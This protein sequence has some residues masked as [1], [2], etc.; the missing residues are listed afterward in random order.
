MKGQSW[1]MDLVIAVVI[2]G[3]IAIIFY[4]II[5]IQQK[6]SVDNL[7]EYAQTIGTKLESN[8]P[9]CGPIINGQSVTPA[10]LSCL[11]DLNYTQLKQ[12]FGIPADF[13]I[14]V[15]DTKG[16]LYIVNTTSG[17]MTGFGNPELV[18]SNTPCGQAIP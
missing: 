1:S 14:Y 11:Y 16:R 10:Q 4:S 6:P 17:L 9:G 12:V 8:I 15:E 13:C 18:V 5:I 3:F 7:Q 2:F